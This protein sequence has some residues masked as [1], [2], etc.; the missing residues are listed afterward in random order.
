[1]VGVLLLCGNSIL[2]AVAHDTHTFEGAS[3]QHRRPRIQNPSRQQVGAG[4]LAKL[5]VS[6]SVPAPAYLSFSDFLLLPPISKSGRLGELAL[7]QLG[8]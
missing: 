6:R 5:P 3:G 8:N 7:V 4:E 2:W 1:M